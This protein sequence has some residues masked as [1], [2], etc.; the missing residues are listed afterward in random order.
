MRNE[1]DARTR[2]EIVAGGAAVGGALVAG[3][4]SGTEQAGE[5]DRDESNTDAGDESY[6]VSMEPM[7]EVT[8]ESVPE[9][10]MA[11]FS[12]YGDMGIALGQLDG[13]E[14]L[15]FA[16]NWPDQFYETVPGLGVDLGDVDQLMG[17]SGIDKETF[18]ELDCD[19]HLFDRNF[20][21]RLD[22]S[23]D[24]DDFDE[25]DSAVGPIFGN[26]IRR[27]GEEW[28][29]YTY[30]S[31]Y[32]AFEKIADVFQERARYGAIK[33]IHDEFVGTIETGLP[34]ENE[35][36]EIGLF[37][38]NSD[39]DGGSFYAYPIVGG[40]EHKHLRDLGIRDAFDQHIDGTHTEWDY[41]QLL[42]V[43]PDVLVFSFG[44]SHA[45][46]A[47][48]DDRMAALRDHPVGSK[49]AAVRNDRLYR[50]GTAYQGPIINLIQ[51]EIAAKQFYPDVFGEWNGVEALAEDD[52]QLFDHRRI[53]EIVGGSI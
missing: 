15:I 8:F 23:W 34:P 4:V 7:G 31:L 47:E 40:N 35:R 20:I 2:R 30:Y 53:G 43:D 27:R 5:S 41:E 13:L 25:I 46:A 42:E 52:E 22:D 44:F 48:F 18:Y 14:A 10:W 21:A 33:A 26:L 6:T 51:T 49:L 29:D 9:R 19:V 50:G 36:P 12:T 37:S 28:H 39:F 17:D 38:I 3:C 45:T 1:I 32:E 11:Y 16:E 24:D